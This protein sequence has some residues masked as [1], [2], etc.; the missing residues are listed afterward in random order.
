MR[1]RRMILVV[2]LVL[3]VGLM[4]TPAKSD[5]LWEKIKESSG[6]A[7][8]LATHP[9]DVLDMEKWDWECINNGPICYPSPTPP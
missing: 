8:Y 2:M 5:T 9:K 3:A 6:A 7:L 4:M 1:S